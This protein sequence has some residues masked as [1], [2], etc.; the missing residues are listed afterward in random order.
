MISLIENENYE[1]VIGI[2]SNL[3]RFSEELFSF[4]TKLDFQLKI[5]HVV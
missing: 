4:F 5:L 2:R 3:P 1:F